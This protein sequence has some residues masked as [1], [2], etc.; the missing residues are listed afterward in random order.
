MYRGAFT[1]GVLDLHPFVVLEP[2]GDGMQHRVVKLAV[3]VVDG[4]VSSVHGHHF[5]D[6]GKHAVDTGGD[7]DSLRLTS[8]AFDR[9][10]DAQG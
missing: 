6:G 3:R 4:R 10:V 1:V 7:L 5:G 9:A 2:L 8:E